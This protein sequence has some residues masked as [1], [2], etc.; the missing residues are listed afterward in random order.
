MSTQTQS[1][2]PSPAQTPVTQEKA[3]FREHAPEWVKQL[4]RL[5]FPEPNKEFHLLKPDELQELLNSVDAQSAA[6]IQEDM[7]YLDKELLR[8]FKDRDYDAKV[9]QNNYRLYQIGY[10]ILSTAA[11][12][13]GAFLAVALDS[14]PEVVP[15]LGFLETLVALLTTYLATISGREAPL[16]SWLENRRKAEHLRREYFRY[17]MDLAP[18]DALEGYHRRRM[19]AVRAADINR[20]FFPETDGNQRT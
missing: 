12:V 11:T 9:H 18:Y 6:R 14:N 1:S 17:L 8:L 19:L 7:V 10:M 13:I 15:I 4:P 3:G 16:P 5:K 2:S 20:G